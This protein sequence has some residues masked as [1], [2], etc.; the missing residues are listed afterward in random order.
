MALR[1]LPVIEIDRNV[2]FGIVYGFQ[3]Y[4]RPST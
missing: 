2:I 1:A 3:L 4:T